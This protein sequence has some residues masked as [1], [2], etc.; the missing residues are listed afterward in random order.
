MEKFEARTKEGFLKKFKES[1][2]K[3]LFFK[4]EKGELTGV[5]NV[6]YFFVEKTKVYSFYSIE[7]NNRIVYPEIESES[8]NRFMCQGDYSFLSEKEIII[9]FEGSLSAFSG[10]LYL[11]KGDSKKRID[12]ILK[13]ES[14]LLN[15]KIDNVNYSIVLE[16]MFDKEDSN[17][18]IKSYLSRKGILAEPRCMNAEFKKYSVFSKIINK[19]R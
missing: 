13:R 19:S 1:K 4:G 7:G 14:C 9:S 10:W 8:D 16:D 2:S 11:L 12:W 5:S 18:T 6:E 3:I 15:T 17:E